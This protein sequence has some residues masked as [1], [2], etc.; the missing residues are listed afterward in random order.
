LAAIRA[1]RALTF[2]SASSFIP[3]EDH[4]SCGC[5]VPKSVAT[6]LQAVKDPVEKPLDLFHLPTSNLGGFPTLDDGD[7]AG[8][9]ANV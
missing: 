8:E 2:A 1:A 6:R 5:S 7:E 4:R 3:T 9:A